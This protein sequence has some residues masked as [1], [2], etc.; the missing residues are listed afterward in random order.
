MKSG[1]ICYELISTGTGYDYAFILVT[2]ADLRFQYGC[3]IGRKLGKYIPSICV[4]VTDSFNWEEFFVSND[5]TTI[6]TD[7]IVHYIDY[8]VEVFVKNF[9]VT[10]NATHPQHCYDIDYSI[11]E[12]F[13]YTSR[14]RFSLDL[15]ETNISSGSHEYLTMYDSCK[16]NLTLCIYIYIYIYNYIYML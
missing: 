14:E 11:I 1:L 9:E 15:L 7:L 13:L 3:Y 12:R 6:S 2:T 5:A 10:L 8:P 4:G 16:C